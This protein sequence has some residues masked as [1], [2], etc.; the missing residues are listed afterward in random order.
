VS[1]LK[2]GIV[3][4]DKPIS[5]NIRLP[6]QVYRDLEAYAG[7]LAEETN[8]PRTDVRKLIVPIVTHFLASDRGFSKARRQARRS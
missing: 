2:L 6:A 4:S 1:K 5:V 8:Q 7:A 3:E